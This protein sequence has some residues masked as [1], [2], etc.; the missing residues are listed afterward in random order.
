[1]KKKNTGFLYREQ[2]QKWWKL[3]KIYISIVEFYSL[4]S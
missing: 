3:V 2:K 1:M 4:A